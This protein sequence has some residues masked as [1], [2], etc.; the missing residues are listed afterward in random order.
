MGNRI[1]H[2]LNGSRVLLIDTNSQEWKNRIAT[3]KF[4]EAEG[5][6][7][8]A[9]GHLMLQDHEDGVSFRNLFVR[10]IR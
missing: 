8:N 3:S 6:G 7:V 2:W 10:E 1:E 5:F 9:K 4:A